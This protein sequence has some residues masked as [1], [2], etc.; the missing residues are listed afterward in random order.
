MQR[1]IQGVETRVARVTAGDELAVTG[2]MSG[3]VDVAGTLWVDLEGTV[4]GPVTVH[5]CGRVL[6]DGV[7]TGP[8]IVERGGDLV[9]TALGSSFGP[10]TNHGSV[11]VAGAIGSATSGLPVVLVG[12]GKIIN[13]DPGKDGTTPHG[14]TP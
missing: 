1:L 11:R 12:S 3:P 5:D 14:V 4:A 8:V 2:V 9:V 10:L 6:V 13:E 7:L